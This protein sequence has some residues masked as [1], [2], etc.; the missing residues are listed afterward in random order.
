MIWLFWVVGIIVVLL[1]IKVL[2]G[3]NSCTES[4][5]SDTGCG[6]CQHSSDSELDALDIL[7]KRFA[8]GDIDEETFEKMKRTLEGSSD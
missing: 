3:N 4:A 2:F 7:K 1:M 8:S 6:S 5:E